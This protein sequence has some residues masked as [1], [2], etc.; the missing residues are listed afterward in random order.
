ML[1]ILI[2]E[3]YPIEA[4]GIYNTLPGTRCRDRGNRAMIRKDGYD[5][6]ADCGVYVGV[7]V[8][9]QPNTILNRFLLA[10]RYTEKSR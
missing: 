4:A 1:G 7:L 8:R 5:F 6:C 3:G 2:E 9:F 10:T